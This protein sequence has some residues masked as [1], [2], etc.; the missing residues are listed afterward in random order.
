M[1]NH[2]ENHHEGKTVDCPNCQ[3]P[4]QNKTALKRHI[5]AVH[6]KKRPHTCVICN[7]SFAQKPH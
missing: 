1:R 4:F 2:I 7:E 6:E 5:E 3:N